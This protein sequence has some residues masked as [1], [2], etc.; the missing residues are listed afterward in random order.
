MSEILSGVLKLTFGF[1]GNKIRSEVAKR[2][3]DGDVTDEE[4][5]RLIARELDDI[6]SKLDGLARKDLL[7]SLLFLQE[8]VNRLYQSL[9]QST[10][11]ENTPESLPLLSHSHSTESSESVTAVE[12]A[13]SRDTAS[14]SPVNEAIALIKAISSLKIHSNERF[15]SAIESFKLAREKATE[16][17]CNEALS[18]EDRIQASQIRM[19]A[20]I[21]GSLEDPDAGVSDCLQYL[22]QLHDTG[23]IRE[24]F[25]VLIAGGLKS[26]FNKTKRINNAS[27]VYAMNEILFDFARKFTKPPPKIF[28]WPTIL[29]G[30]RIYHPVFGDDRVVKELEK[31]DVKVMQPSYDVTFDESLDPRCSAVNSK[32]EIVAKMFSQDTCTLNMF[33]RSGESRKLCDVPRKGNL[34]RWRVC[35]MDVD[36][37]DNIYVIT[38]FEER[39]DVTWRFNL[40]IFDANGNK[41]LECPLPFVQKTILPTVSMAINKQRKI[42]ILDRARIKWCT[43]EMCVSS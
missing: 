43:L 12:A 19:M 22:K 8:G 7:S 4:C 40:F 13:S 15:K 26:M 17:F 1:L 6:K 18:I 28:D 25:S 38:A 29:V 37:E 16:A 30:E 27:A 36:E 34:K 20:R 21:L 42:A 32:G 11:E 2:L 31:S 35:A 24:T 10:S 5:R 3:E 39:E 33:K 9:L 23:V 41:K 14:H